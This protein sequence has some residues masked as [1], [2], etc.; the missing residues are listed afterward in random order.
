MPQQHSA[1]L[2]CGST[3]FVPLP[4]FQHAGLQ[5]CRDCGFV[6]AVQIPTVAELTAHYNTYSRNDYIS[7]IT[8][9]RYEELLDGFEAYRKTNKIIDVGCGNGH[10]LK[11]ALQR[12]W[13]VY[14]TEYTDEAIAQ[15]K[16]K[17]ILMQQGEL[18]PANYATESFDVI[19]SFEVLE[20]INTPHQEIK[21]FHTLLRQGG[22]VYLTTPN[23][24]AVSKNLLKENWS[25]VEYPEHL[26]YY[27][28]KTLRKLFEKHNFKTLEVLTT[29][30]SIGRIQLA[31]SKQQ[32]IANQEHTT[33]NP[34]NFRTE[35]ETLRQ[36]AESNPF[37]KFAKNTI[38]FLLNTTGKGD[39]L[40]GYFVKK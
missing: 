7:P 32:V 28:P 38:N 31:K 30:V 1:C 40:K 2:L 22:L 4:T 23:F 27:T 21:H 5:Q 6:F 18:N 8:V 24:N 11:V 14:G 19:T 33:S 36:Q 26:S 16:A 10:F 34:V 9:K 35:D 17:G 37:I 12:G 3:H 15:C 25:V 13:E 39:S 20:H 29:G